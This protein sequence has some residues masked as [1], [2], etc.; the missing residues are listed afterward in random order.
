MPRNRGDGEDYLL[1][2][3]VEARGRRRLDLDKERGVLV[4]FDGEQRDNVDVSRGIW[5]MYY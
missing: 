1:A 5:E 2:L 3:R 4:E